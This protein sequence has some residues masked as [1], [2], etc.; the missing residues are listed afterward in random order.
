[1]GVTTFPGLG[2]KERRRSH[3]E[4]EAKEYGY[5]EGYSISPWKNRCPVEEAK[6]EKC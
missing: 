4:E 2:P 3:P 5:P 1:M 6:E